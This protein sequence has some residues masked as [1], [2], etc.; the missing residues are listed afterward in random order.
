MMAEE[1][2][3]IVTFSYHLQSWQDEPACRQAGKAKQQNIIS[4]ALTLPTY[5]QA[6][7]AGV[8]AERLRN[9]NAKSAA[10]CTLR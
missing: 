7:S 9:I 10:R 6:G 1:Y 3:L 8:R 5:R 4:L 2:V